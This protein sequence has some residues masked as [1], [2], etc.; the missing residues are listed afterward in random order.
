MWRHWYSTFS[1]INRFYKKEDLLTFANSSKIKLY[2][3]QNENTNK[4]LINVAPATWRELMNIQVN[5]FSNLNRRGY[6]SK[7]VMFSSFATSIFQV[8][9]LH[10]HRCNR[11]YFITNSSKESRTHWH[12]QSRFWTV[13]MVFRLTYLFFVK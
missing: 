6:A 9:L 10:V 5:E 7:H 3:P 13:S 4:V 1:N 8:N 2:L 12:S 11:H